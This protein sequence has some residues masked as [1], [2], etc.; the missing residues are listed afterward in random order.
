MNKGAVDWADSLEAGDRMEQRGGSADSLRRWRGF[1]EQCGSL[2]ELH[3][4]LYSTVVEQAPTGRQGKWIPSSCWADCGSRCFNK[5]YVVDGTVIRQGTE[6]DREDRPEDPQA[7]SCSR[8]RMRRHEVFGADRLKYPM[9]RRHWKPGGGNRSLRGRDE[10]IRISWDEALELVADEI[11]RIK[12]AYG[13]HA[14]LVPAYVPSLF[15]QWDIGRTLALYGGYVGNWGA[16]S[17]GSWGAAGP[18]IGLKED[19][20]D[21]LDMQNCELIVLWGYNP[22]WSRAGLPMYQY[23][24]MKQAGTRFISIDP[25]FNP[26]AHVLE[27]EWVPC[28][29]ATDHALV[30]G[31]IHTLIDEDHPIDNPLIDWDFLHRCTVGFDAGHMPEGT[32]PEENFRDYVMGVRDGAPKSPEWAAQICGVPPQQIRSLARRIA[33][34]RK[35]AICMSPAPARNTRAD[36]WPQAIMALGAMTGHIGTTG[37]M[38]GSDTGHH[39]LVEGPPL[40]RGGTIQGDPTPW[41]PGG[42]K[43]IVNP[44]D[45]GQGMYDHPKGSRVRINNNEL[46]EAVLTGKYTAGYQDIRDINIQMIY[47]VHSNHLNQNP[48][49]MRAIEAHR[50]VEFVVTHNYVPTSTARYS[51]IILPVTTHWERAG[52][53]SQGFREMMLWSSQLV[54]PMFDARDD[55]WIAREIG[56]RLGLD[57]E[58]IEPVSPKQNLFNMVAA[59]T[60]IRED[61]ATWQPL[62]T[63]TERDL[64]VLGV[65]GKPQEGRVPILEFKEKGIYN[66]PRKHGDN[67]GH[68]VLQKFREDPEANP[69]DTASGKLEIHCQALSDA[70]KACGWSEVPP[71]PEYQRPIEGYE[72]TFKDWENKVKGD[73]PLQFFDL[74][75]LRQIHSSFA[76]IPALKEAF[77]L[78]LIMNP[79]DA[80][81]RSLV[82][83]DAVLV[84]SR[85]GKVL[86]PVHLTN[87]MMPGVCAIGQ[88]AW[89]EIDEETGIDIGGCVNVLHGAIPSGHGHMGWNSCNV[90]VSKWHGTPLQSDYV[91]S[92]EMFS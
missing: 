40:V 15:G 23:T 86:R 7:R 25:Y 52:D 54:D 8:G 49:T 66:I 63:I 2:N 60:V 75:V 43:Q 88:G 51:D 28:R 10:W 9:R 72:D 56:A 37:R 44:L 59:A 68:V 65:E 78:D 38:T 1:V 74:H 80:R 73:Y 76:N 19:F 67:L 42:M 91:R 16:C 57:P 36:S 53:I 79:L 84:E 17:S 34:T 11:R 39:W 87:E 26:T 64:E 89:V 90:Q 85:H 18:I 41:T 82:E 92:Q 55:L 35:V 14:F 77:T 5:A 30:L 71:I 33:G 61:G 20:S 45:G 81:E 32:D 50:Q 31:M 24:R 47:H 69:L 3:S 58:V 22:A 12:E 48:G 46:W 70:V 27:A 4:G 6:D 21:R 13:N 29:P 83:G 62:V